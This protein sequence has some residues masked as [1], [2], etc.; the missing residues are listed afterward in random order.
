[1]V[2]TRELQ[3]PPLSPHPL[4]WPSQSNAQ[5]IDGP[6]APT[7][8]PT[9]RRPDVRA[10]A[11]ARGIAT[12]LRRPPVPHPQSEHPQ[13]CLS[14]APASTARQRIRALLRSGVRDVAIGRRIGSE[15]GGA[16]RITSP[17]V[18]HA[19]EAP[20]SP[21]Q[22]KQARL[23]EAPAPDRKSS[24]RSGLPAAADGRCPRGSRAA[25]SLDPSRAARRV[26]ANATAQLGRGC[27]G[28]DRRAAAQASAPP[29]QRAARASRSR[30]LC[31]GK[32]VA[33]GDEGP[34]AIAGRHPLAGGAAAALG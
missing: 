29:A 25:R 3:R 10:P 20:V 33:Q 5:P 26:G 18:F 15:C 7:S 6:H 2:A 34:R 30:A 12:R 4:P 31:A 23:A 22:A 8:C 16:R 21:L 28:G 1:V 17:P 9:K 32:T 13:L 24:G 14:R 11:A 19:D 27:T